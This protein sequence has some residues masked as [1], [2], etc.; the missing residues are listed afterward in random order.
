MVMLEPP[1]LVTVSESDCRFPT[2]TLPKLRAVGFE[3]S[4]PGAIPVPDNRMV[5]VGVWAFELIATLPLTLPAD[6]GVNVTLKVVLCPAVR[7][8]GVTIPLRL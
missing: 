8:N 2:V 3:P 4:D 6:P 1:V 7:V 5:R